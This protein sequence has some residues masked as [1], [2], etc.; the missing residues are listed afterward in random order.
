MVNAIIIEARTN[1]SRLPG[2]VLKKVLNKPL[3]EFQIERLKKVKNCDEI[4][5][6]TTTHSDDDE[7]IKIA[8]ENKIK[9]FRGP[10]LDV[11]QRVLDTATYFSVKNIIE[12]PGDCPLIDAKYVDFNINEFFKRKI[13]YLS[14]H[15]SKTWPNGFESQI[16]S[17]KV[18]KDVSERSLTSA[19]REHVSQFI[20]NN[21]KLYSIASINSPFNKKYSKVK[22]TLDTLEDFKIIKKIITRLYPINKNFSLDDILKTFY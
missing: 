3:L 21:P 11:L 16:F 8:I 15:L 9:F 19:D 10:E 5:I 17:T 22:L 1:S 20:Y 12:I 13:D 4:I 6:A 14:S 18:L 7:I 2:K